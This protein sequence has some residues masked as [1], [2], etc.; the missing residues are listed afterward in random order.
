MSK[1][2]IISRFDEDLDWLNSIKNFKKIIYNKGRNIQDDSLGK[3]INIKN[4][5]RE[6]HTWIYNIFNN[7]ENLKI[8]YFLPVYH[9]FTS[10]PVLR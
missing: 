7:Y 9:L 8:I 2:L 1:S 6:S 3:I 4:V 10:G 5:G